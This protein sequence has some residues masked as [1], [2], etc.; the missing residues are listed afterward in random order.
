MIL[1]PGSMVKQQENSEDQHTKTVAETL[2]DLIGFDLSRFI[3]L[4]ITSKAC[5]NHVHNSLRLARIFLSPQIKRSVIIRNNWYI[6]ASSRLA[7]QLK[8]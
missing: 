6:R 1:K 4:F 5:K 3:L 2:Y 7:K 8:T